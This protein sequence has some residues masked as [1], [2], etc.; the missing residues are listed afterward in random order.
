[1]KNELTYLKYF[2]HWHM[3]WFEEEL[4]LQAYAVKHLG[5]LVCAVQEGSELR[6]RALTEEIC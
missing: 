4:T 6:G 1:M 3:L 5:P 2:A